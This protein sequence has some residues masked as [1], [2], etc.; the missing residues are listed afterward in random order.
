LS[1]ACAAGN[2]A[3]SLGYDLIKQ[4]KAKFFLAGGADYFSTSIFL[5]FY[6]LFSLAPLKCQP[7]DKNRRGLLP[8]EGA[9]MLVLESL[10][11]AIKRKAKIYAEILGYGAS[12]DAYHTVIPS[13]DGVYACMENALQMS[14]LTTDSIDYISAHGTG[15][16]PND[17][18]ECAAIG[19]LFGD[20]SQR[21][22]I[23]SIKSMLGHTMGA[24]SSI[25]AIS[26]CLAIDRGSIPPTINYD[27][28]DPEC[29]IDCVP[30]E[31]REQKTKIALN[32]SF[33]FGGTNCSLVI[34]NYMS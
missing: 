11:S 12:V 16:I 23:S 22:P 7:F 30:N 34:A 21:V 2:Y 24:A 8:A 10:S 32:N 14:G 27:T 9:G 26:C 17:R 20:R 33:G 29:N 3:I 31:A 4:G 28:A 19:K 1:C 5:S 6:K 13:I 18:V 15:T 25:E